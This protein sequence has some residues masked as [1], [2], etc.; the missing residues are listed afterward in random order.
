[1]LEGPDVDSV[2]EHQPAPAQ[3]HQDPAPHASKLRDG[4]ESA[5]IGGTHDAS[6]LHL[7][8]ENLAAAGQDEVDIGRAGLGSAG[9]SESQTR[10]TV[11]RVRA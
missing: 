1:M 8:C 2:R 3:I 4:A 6:T 5:Q 7:E 9:S 10:G 11:P